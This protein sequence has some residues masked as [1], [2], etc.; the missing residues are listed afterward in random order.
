MAVANG[1][2]TEK[3]QEPLVGHYSDGTHFAV[4]FR[5]RPARKTWNWESGVDLCWNVLSCYEGALGI[6]R[7]S[8]VL[9]DD[10]FSLGSSCALDFVCALDKQV[11]S[12]GRNFTNRSP[13]VVRRK[14]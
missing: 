13:S 4:F 5:V 7:S 12:S 11:D 2:K 3:H 9:D 1:G 6:K 14:Y 8:M 10:C